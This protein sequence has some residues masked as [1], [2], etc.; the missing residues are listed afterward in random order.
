MTNLYSFTRFAIGAAVFLMT[1]CAKESDAVVPTSV[2][3]A[4]SRHFAIGDTWP[5]GPQATGLSC[6]VLMK[7]VKETIPGNGGYFAHW[8]GQASCPPAEQLVYKGEY[9]NTDGIYFQYTTK[10]EPTGEVSMIT[11]YKISKQ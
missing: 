2:K 5:Q 4:P 7:V 3:A 11:F 9:T 8:T 1:G 6:P 10:T